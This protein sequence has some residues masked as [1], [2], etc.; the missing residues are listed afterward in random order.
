MTKE[1]AIVEMQN[2]N[3]ISHRFFDIHEYIHMKNKILYDE[4]GYHINWKVFW[5]DRTSK[6]WQTEWE[7]Y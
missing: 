3:K 4:V 1:E 6:E 7:L 5:G 2:G